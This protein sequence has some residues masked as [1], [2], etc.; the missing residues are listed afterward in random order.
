MLLLVLLQTGCLRFI[1]LHEPIEDTTS[2]NDSVPSGLLYLVDERTIV[3]QDNESKKRL[4]EFLKSRKYLEE[5]NS[6]QVYRIGP[7][8]LLDISVFD[9]PELNTTE[10]VDPAG[11]ISLNLVGQ[12][13]AAGQTE[14][15]LRANIEDGLRK[16]MRKPQVRLFI[17]EYRS[18]K[19][20]VNGAVA[21][22]GTF[23]L[24]RDALSLM[25]ILSSA[26]GRTEKSGSAIYVLPQST[27]GL[28]RIEVPLNLLL[29]TTTEP[30]TF[31]P[32]IAGDTIVVPEAGSV[33]VDG[34]VKKPGS[35]AL[36]SEMTVL[37]S[38]ASAGGLTYSADSSSVEIIRNIGAGN[39][40]LVRLDLDDIGQRTAQNFRL[41][42]GDVISVPSHASKFVIRQFV[43]VV[44]SLF[45]FGVNQ[46]AP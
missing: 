46:N 5:G 42:D 1:P 23:P 40:A 15:E 35:F 2:K 37:G 12:I 11:Y 13:Y 32:I 22:P 4:T 45:R 41:R 25:E 14:T 16:F 44:E 7:D 9:V 34:E 24:E 38:I 39:K 31:V 30:P 3:A 17:K 10:R 21:R 8:D 19:V 43:E 29:G 33:Q 26:G 27:N 6:G 18:R 36:N 20:S 28:Q